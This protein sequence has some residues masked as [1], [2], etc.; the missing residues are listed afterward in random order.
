MRVGKFSNIGPK[1][2]DDEKQ[3]ALKKFALHEITNEIVMHIKN[4]RFGA[5]LLSLS[6]FK[7]YLP[8]QGGQWT[9]Y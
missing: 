8:G 1:P 9:G 7:I 4:N 3:E 2:S 6:W 5:V